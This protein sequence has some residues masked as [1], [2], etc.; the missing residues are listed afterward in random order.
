MRIAF[1]EI[2]DPE[3]VKTWSGIPYFILQELRRQ[4]AEVEVIAPL[5]RPFKYLYSVDKIVSK[6]TGRNI[7]VNRRPVAL[8]SFASQVDRRMRGK[9]FDVIFSTS[10]IPI[11]RLKPGIPVLFWADAVTEAM[12]DYYGGAFANIG[13]R[14]LCVAHAQEQA[15]LDRASFAIYSSNWAAEIVKGLYR[16]SDDKVRVI[17]FGA[18]LPI[19]HDLNDIIAFNEQRLR[20]QCNLLFIGVDWDRKG[21]ATAFEAAKILNERGIKTVLKVVGGRGPDSPF[22]ESLGFINKNTPEGLRQIKSLLSTSTFFILPTRAEAA[23]VVFCEA[24][25]FGLPTLATRTGGVG[26]YV[27]DSQTGFCLPSAADGGAYANLIAETLASPETYRQLSIGAFQG[28]KQTLNWDVGVS[29]LL[30]LVERAVK[31]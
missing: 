2:E 25:A 5:A 13:Y 23:G 22:V 1:V 12:V 14:E 21:G 3:D 30:S 18:N 17:A 31:S 4:G 10:S 11:S 19:D 16:S 9:Q 24:G 28:Y 8:R 26:D 7:Q 27:I 15:A 6:L 29:S 20:S